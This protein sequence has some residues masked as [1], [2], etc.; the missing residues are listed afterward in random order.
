MRKLLLLCGLGFASLNFQVLPSLA[1]MLFIRSVPSDLIELTNGSHGRHYDLWRAGRLPVGR[2]TGLP[3]CL[4]IGRFNEDEPPHALVDFCACITQPYSAYG[5]DPIEGRVL[6][7]AKSRP[8]TL[9]LSGIWRHGDSNQTWTFTRRQGVIFDAV[10]SGFGNAR[11]TA[12]VL[13]P[14][15]FVID[16]TV[17]GNVQGRYT[18]RYIGNSNW[19]GVWAEQGAGKSGT[20]TFTKI[21]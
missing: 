15:E 8:C 2:V 5:S 1:D 11:G 7:F 3:G 18:V 9:N 10:E 14:W 6:L 19:E 12:R 17:R 13:N 21:Q 16:Y 20:R 4:A